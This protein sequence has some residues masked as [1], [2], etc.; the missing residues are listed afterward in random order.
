MYVFLGAMFV[1]IDL[2][3]VA[4]ATSFGHKPLAGVMLG[5]LGARQRDGGLWYGSRNWRAPT[6]RRFAIT[7]ALTVAGVCTFWAV[8]NL[9]VLA[10]VISCAGWR[11]R[12]R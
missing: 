8:P 7:L 5:L 6:W 10:L 12:R 2:S 9:L 4:F 11:S 3:T 1:S